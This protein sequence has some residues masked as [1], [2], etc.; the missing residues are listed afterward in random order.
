MDLRYDRDFPSQSCLDG[1]SYHGPKCGIKPNKTGTKKTTCGEYFF[2]KP[3]ANCPCGGFQVDHMVQI[4]RPF[5]L[6][7]T[8]LIILLH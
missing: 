1:S 3:F 5:F 2:K 7:N 8:Q 4:R 6:K